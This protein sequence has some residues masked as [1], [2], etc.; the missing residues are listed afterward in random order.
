MNRESNPIID[1]LNGYKL[2]VYNKDLEAFAELYAKD[3]HAFDMWGQWSVQGI[4]DW[5]KETGNWFTS[6][7]SERVVVKVEDV[8]CYQSEGLASGHA[9][10]TYAAISGEGQELRSL[11]NRISITVRQTEQGWKI[12]HQHTSAPID[13]NTMKPHLHRQSR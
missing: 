11:Q 3:I 4:A 6:L 12:V 13:F 10:L 5:K 8:S 2:A 9:T 1:T 7:G